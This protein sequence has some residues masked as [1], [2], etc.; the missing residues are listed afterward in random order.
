MHNTAN[1]IVLARDSSQP[2]RNEI[3]AS[4][5]RRQDDSCIASNP[6]ACSNCR[7]AL[8]GYRRSVRVPHAHVSNGVIRCI[9]GSGACRHALACASE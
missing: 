8:R 2:T 7:R 4:E 6:L 9:S 1:V 5:N 3:H